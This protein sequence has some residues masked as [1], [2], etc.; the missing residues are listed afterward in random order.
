MSKED[1]INFCN[2][3]WEKPYGFAVLDLDSH[4]NE[5]KYRCGLDKFFIPQPKY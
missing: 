5:G 3:C 1:F 4:R 2:S